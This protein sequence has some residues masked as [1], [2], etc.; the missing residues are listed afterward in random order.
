MKFGL[1]VKA[2]ACNH[3]KS[4]EEEKEEF[5]LKKDDIF[6]VKKNEWHQIINPYEEICKIIEIQ[7][8]EKV[9]ESDIERLR[10][11]NESV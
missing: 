1:L 9:E 10:Y 2:P 11:Y 7:Y 4:T 5:I 6:Q 3:S 8:G